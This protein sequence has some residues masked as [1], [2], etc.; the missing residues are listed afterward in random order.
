MPHDYD[1]RYLSII[2]LPRSQSKNLDLQPLTQIFVTSYLFLAAKNVFI[3][4][5][6]LF[7]HQISTP[8]TRTAI[9]IPA[10]KTKYTPSISL[11]SRRDWDTE[12]QQ[13]NCLLR[14]FKPNRKTPVD[15]FSITKRVSWIVFL[16]LQPSIRLYMSG[17]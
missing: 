14:E 3:V 12:R 15:R 16:C 11:T 4:F 1:E 6:K 13:S 7:F 9:T 10:D 2:S 17:C 5:P 8:T